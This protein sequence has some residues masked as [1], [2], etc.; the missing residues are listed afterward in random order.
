MNAYAMLTKC[1]RPHT[2]QEKEIVEHF[3]NHWEDDNEKDDAQKNEQN[4]EMTIR[5]KNIL[6]VQEC[7]LSVE[8]KVLICAVPPEGE[9]VLYFDVT[10]LSE[11]WVSLH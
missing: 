1:K 3:L 7:S 5:V 6:N 11:N 4:T 9:L 8:D 2:I 10:D